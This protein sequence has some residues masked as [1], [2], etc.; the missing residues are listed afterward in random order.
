M[1]VILLDSMGNDLTVVNAARVSFNKVSEQF[2]NKDKRLV[3][4]LANHNH[5]TPFTQITYQV[6]ISAPIFVARQWFKHQIGISRNEISRRYVNDLPEFYKPDHWRSKVD[7]KK[8][9]SGPPLKETKHAV[10]NK[11]DALMKGAA[12]TYRRMLEL[13]VCE[14]QARI[15]LPQ[16]MMT[17]WI[18]TG[19]LAAASRIVSL[20]N[21]K[22]AQI[23]IQQLAEMFEEEVKHIAPYSWEALKRTQNE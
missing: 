20:R 2:D 7:N 11:Y 18:E 13:G 22:D 9:G 6:R 21:H 14:E 17:E 16:S 3:D 15:V 8:Q 10:Q 23:E 1:K 12:R 19:S 5:F 4:Y